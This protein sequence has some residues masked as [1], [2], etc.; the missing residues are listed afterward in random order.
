MDVDDEFT[1][2]VKFENGAIGSI[3][4][5]RNAWGRNNF[6]TFEIHGDKG[7]ICFNYERRDEFKVCFSDDPADAKGFRTFYTGPA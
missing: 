3:E 4:A 1:T 6:L 2:L 5:T 7:S